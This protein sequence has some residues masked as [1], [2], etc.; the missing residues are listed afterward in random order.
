MRARILRTA[1][2]RRYRSA[3]SVDSRHRSLAMALAHDI[4]TLVDL[5][6]QQLGFLA[7]GGDR[8]I[9]IGFR[10]CIGAPD[11]GTDSTRQRL[12]ALGGHP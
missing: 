2:S 8:P 10:W 6:L 4:D 7:G 11:L 1:C 5:T 9:R 12:C 3:S